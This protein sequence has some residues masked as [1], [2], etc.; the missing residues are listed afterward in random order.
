MAAITG[1]IAEAKWGEPEDIARD[2]L[3]QLDHALVEVHNR[4][5]TVGAK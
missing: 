2:A 3:G 5:M 4:F 1:S